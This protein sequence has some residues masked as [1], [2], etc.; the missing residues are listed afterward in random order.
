MKLS[1]MT[2]RQYVMAEFDRE[3]RRLRIRYA[4]VQLPENI[5]NALIDL[6]DNAEEEIQKRKSK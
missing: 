5:L 3:V 4:K 1:R 2:R 6:A